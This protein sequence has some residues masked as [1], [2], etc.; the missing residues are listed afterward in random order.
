MAA[1]KAYEESCTAFHYAAA[2]PVSISHM[3]SRPSRLE[4][5]QNQITELQS[6]VAKLEEA[7]SRVLKLEA[8]VA[9]LEATVASL[10]RDLVNVE[11][12]GVYPG[13]K[14]FQRFTL[15]EMGTRTSWKPVSAKER[16]PTKKWLV[17]AT[18]V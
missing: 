7:Q 13:T 18:R 9:S 6:R 12:K 4:A 11:D 14:I 16:I 1:A 2:T 15:R 3:L 10:S 5:N 8:R 17:T